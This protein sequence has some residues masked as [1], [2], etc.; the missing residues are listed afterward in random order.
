MRVEVSVVATSRNGW[1]QLD[2]GSAGMLRDAALKHDGETW[3]LTIAAPKRQRST[4]QNRYLHCD[5]FFGELVVAFGY[6]E[7]KDDKAA[8]DRLKRDLCGECFGWVTTPRGHQEPAKRTSE[9][10]VEDCTQLIEWAAR[11]AAECGV[12]IA[13]P[14]KGAA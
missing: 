12:Y 2:A 5:A 3:T 10:S 13:M 9:L 4:R 14:Q 8:K 1:W 6:S 11:E 7:S